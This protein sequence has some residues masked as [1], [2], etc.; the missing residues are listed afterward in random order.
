MKSS[1]FS[2]QTLTE[3]E[4]ELLADAY[5]RG[6]K[7]PPKMALILGV[8]SFDLNSLMHPLTRAGIIR[9]QQSVRSL[10]SLEDHIDKLKEIRDAAFEAE[11]YK[12]ALAAETQ[13]GKAA[14]HYDPK[15]PTDPESDK[16]EE[17]AKLSTDQLRRRL[18][19]AVG[20]VIPVSEQEQIEAQ[21]GDLPPED[22][23]NLV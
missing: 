15:V 3:A 19:K 16:P 4:A 9:R 8:D 2:V 13:V 23:D 20:A 1:A 14:G 5:V 17:I 7:D 22:E 6:D 12:V 10:H 18:A 11:N 21:P